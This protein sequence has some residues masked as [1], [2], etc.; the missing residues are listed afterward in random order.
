MRRDCECIL[1]ESNAHRAAWAGAR[2]STLKRNGTISLGTEVQRFVLS[3]Y[4]QCIDVE[5]A[6]KGILTTFAD[7]GAKQ[8]GIGYKALY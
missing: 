7:C 4:F 6:V 3:M 8:R 5:V 2:S 1:A